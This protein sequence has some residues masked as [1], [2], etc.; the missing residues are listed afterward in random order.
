[1]TPRP[2][3]LFDLPKLPQFRNEIISLDCARILTRGNP[4]RAVN[5][6]AHL[7]PTRLIYT[8][9][10]ENEKR[11]A[12]LGSIR[13][14]HDESFARLTYL[15]P[16]E[17]LTGD[18][19]PLIEHLVGQAKHWHAHQVV[20]EIEED[21]PLFQPLR[22]SGFSVYSRQRVWDLS[23]VERSE[24]S[25]SSWRRVSAVDNIG[26]QSLQRQVV[27]P[28]LQQVENFENPKRGLVCK[29]TETMAYVDTLYGARGIFL[30]PLIH[31]NV[32][33]IQEKLQDMLLRNL[34]NRRGRPVYFCVRSYQAW[35]EPILEEMEASVGPRM[36]VMVKHLASRQL[37]EKSVPRGADVV[38]SNPAASIRSS[39]IKRS[40]K[41]KT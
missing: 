31:P 4:L 8:A 20:A 13:Q 36:V 2:L 5:F 27:P 19:L 1:M 34:T 24:D 32:D 15:A 30:R 26:I 41:G 14:Q 12:L 7:N 16:L 33:D 3:E 17:A 22:Q 9:I 11:Q 18:A 25:P 23:N 38:W 39:K 40:D 21:S 10:H 29:N 28:L 35:L 37:V 6:L